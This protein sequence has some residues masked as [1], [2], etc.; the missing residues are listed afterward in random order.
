MANT[1][2]DIVITPFRGDANNNPVIKFSSGDATSNLDMNVRFYAVSNGT[3]SFEGPSGQM[4]SVT[5]DMTGSIFSVNDI[6]GLPVI[7]VNANT[8]TTISA[9]SF[10]SNSAPALSITD[11][12]ANSALTFTGLQ[13]NIANTNSGSASLLMDLQLGGASRFKVDKGGTGTF[14]S[15]INALGYVGVGTQVSGGP[16]VC[17]Y[18]SSSYV[19]TVAGGTNLPGFPTVTFGTLMNTTGRGVVVR[20][21]GG[22]AFTNNTSSLGTVDLIINRDAANILAQRNGTAAQ[23]FNIYNT[24]TDASNYERGFIKWNSNTLEFGHEIAGTGSNTRVNKYWLGP[25]AFNTYITRRSDA[26]EI[27]F[28]SNGT[29]QGMF[30]AQLASSAGNGNVGVGVGSADYGNATISSRQFGV[31]IYLN[32]SVMGNS[33]RDG[34]H[35]YL[36]GGTASNSGNWNGGHVYLDGG[37]LNG[38]GING[39][40]VIGN[41][42]STL[43]TFG[44]TTSAYP[45]L[46]QSGTTLQVRLADDSGN[47]NFSCANATFS[48]VLAGYAP[49]RPAFRVYGA[50]TTTNLTTTQNGTGQLNNN[51]WATDFNQGTYLDISTGTFTAPVAGLY[52][53]NV[54]G[55]NSGYSSG[56]SQL[57]VVK[58]PSGTNLV[59]C[60]LEFAASSSMNH[61]GVSTVCQLAA[62]DTLVLKVLAG[63]I[64]F[65]GNDNWSV[66]YVG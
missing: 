61:A 3:L 40:V 49:N 25:T 50:N 14:V 36:Q 59:M 33:N 58:N 8:N 63:E 9:R 51:N 64:N 44:G 16:S 43:T 10:L 62:G 32:P 28:W 41:T 26:Q 29:K 39:K 15:N 17:V 27:E 1:Y 13:L 42:R 21:D 34:A 48:G 19:L 55:R 57:A 4:F 35:L 18:E 6:S 66:S 45:A 22:Y 65:D 30:G 37:A 38:T 60:M 24:Y 12:W 46:K 11:T 52:Q 5:N 56:I 23:T 54:V 20:G 2:K 7:D 47:A 53:V 31:N